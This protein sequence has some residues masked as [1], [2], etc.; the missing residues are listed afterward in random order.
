M[1][2]NIVE[3]VIALERVEL[4]SGLTP[5]QLAQIALIA[6]EVV[7][8]PERI[9]LAPSLPLE[10]LYVI[11]EGA[12][13]ISRNGRQL[14]IARQSEVLGSWA[15]FDDS[16]SPVTAKTLEETAMLRIARDDFYE[17]LSD[18]MELAASIFSTL[19]RRFRKLIEQS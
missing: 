13:E 8:G 17:L 12:V 11:L 16:P 18:H 1:E 10:A 9:I 2:R 7:Y 4:L 3:K 14:H 5:D 19:V 15:L 6:N